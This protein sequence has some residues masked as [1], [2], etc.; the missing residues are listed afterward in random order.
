MFVCQIFQKQSRWLLFLFCWQTSKMQIT[1]HL[2]SFH[3]KISLSTRRFNFSRFFQSW[4]L[5]LFHVKAISL[6]SIYQGHAIVYLLGDYKLACLR[7]NLVV[8]PSAGLIRNVLVPVVYGAV[9]LVIAFV[10]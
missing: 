2:L 3:F 10:L 7:L 9:L 8:L 4:K 1:N 6:T 5:I